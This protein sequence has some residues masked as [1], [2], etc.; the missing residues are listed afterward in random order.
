MRK[1]L[2]TLLFIG[3]MSS[4]VFAILSPIH[5]SVKEIDAILWSRE[6]SQHFNQADTI[7][8]IK[9]VD[10]GYVV[11]TEDKQMMVEVIYIP[12]QRVG[13][14]EFKLVFHPARPYND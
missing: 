12:S 9:R 1:T 13:P 5:Q 8:E 2:F 4:P 14:Q 11:I 6:L 10:N 7:Q 3:M